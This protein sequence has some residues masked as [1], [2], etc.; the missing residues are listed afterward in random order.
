MDDNEKNEHEL[1]RMLGEPR[2]ALFSRDNLYRYLLWRRWDSRNG[3]ALWILL[4]PSTATADRN[5]PTVERCQRRTL[6]MGY[7]G[8]IIANLFALRSTD[9]HVLYGNKRAVGADNDRW[10][11]L[12][13]AAAQRVYCGWGIHGGYKGR[14][15]RVRSVLKGLGVLPYC[16]GTTKEGEPR[17]PL[18]VSYAVLPEPMTEAHIAAAPPAN[19]AERRGCP[20]CE[21]PLT[22]FGLCPVC[23][24]QST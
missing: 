6:E 16:L 23:T 1:Q 7:G 12:A 15:T 20:D 10:I 21:Y 24:G 4:N 13:A 11:E 17:H 14:S 8:I 3:L 9:P 18:Y 2:G 5:D 22:S 19:H